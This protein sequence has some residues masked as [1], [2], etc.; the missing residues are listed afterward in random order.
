L[1]AKLGWNVVDLDSRIKEKQDMEISDIFTQYG[2]AFF[3][4]LESQVLKEIVASKHQVIATGGGAVLSPQNREL[5]KNNGWV[6]ALT[7]D[8]DVIIQRAR[9]DHERPLLKGDLDERVN[10]LLEER[11]DAYQ[12]ADVS[13]DT[14]KL[15]VWQI[16]DQILSEWKG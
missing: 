6:V 1:A 12:F 11:K 9:Q 15:S 10:R 14:S 13:V 5:M 4:E 3:R 2:E 7:A 16:V 8:K